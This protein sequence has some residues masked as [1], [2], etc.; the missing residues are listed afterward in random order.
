VVET[1]PPDPDDPLL[2][3]ENV[4]LSPHTAFYSEESVSQLKRDAA[5]SVVAVLQ[6]RWPKSVVNRDVVGK[7]RASIGAH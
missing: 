4:I 5:E 2:K 3:M 1:E 6:G 7:T